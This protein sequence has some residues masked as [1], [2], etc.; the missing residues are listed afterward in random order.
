MPPNAA[1]GAPLPMQRNRGGGVTG[2]DL[3]PPPEIARWYTRQ[4][5][6]DPHRSSLSAPARYAARILSAVPDELFVTFFSPSSVE[7]LQTALR[8]RVYRETGRQVA[9]DRQ[10]EEQ[11]L[12]IMVRV[13]HERARYKPGTPA[14]RSAQLS[15]DVLEEASR[16]VLHNVHA[17]LTSLATVDM[18][19]S[20]ARNM[21]P[22]PAKNTQ[23]ARSRGV[24]LTQQA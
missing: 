20:R 22:L 12:N 6:V 1:G 13:Y 23:S 14:Q 2:A 9:I 17:Y 4:S 21:P 11:M 7:A 16:V 18:Q 3:M 8:D 19:A 5:Q 10:P 24:P 15:S